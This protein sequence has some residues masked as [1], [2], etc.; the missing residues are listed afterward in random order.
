TPS[1]RATVGRRWLWNFNREDRD[2]AR[3]QP[4]LQTGASIPA[5]AQARELAE[6]SAWALRATRGRPPTKP[7]KSASTAATAGAPASCSAVTPWMARLAGS[8]KFSGSGGVQNQDT[9]STS[10]PFS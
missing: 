5:A 2:N 4:K 9:E 6:T 10:T 8:K 1:T 7:T 3:E